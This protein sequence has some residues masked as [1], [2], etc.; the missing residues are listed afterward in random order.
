MD[1]NPDMKI[2]ILA[3]KE[4]KTLTIRDTG[5][6]MSKESLR[7]HLGTIAKSGTSEFATAAAG[8]A[9]DLIGQF[10]VGFYSSFL[11][12]DSVSVISK[13]ANDSQV[14]FQINISIFGN[15]PP[16]MALPLLKIHVEIL[17]AVDLRLF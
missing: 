16:K 7:L 14:C 1:A 9:T 10:G 4:A 11:V 17:L 6:G 12:A 8:N 3:D 2:T 15:L 13:S 5:I